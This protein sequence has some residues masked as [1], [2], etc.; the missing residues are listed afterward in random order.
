MNQNKLVTLIMIAVAA[1]GV[2]QAV[3]AYGLNHNLWRPL[4]VMACVLGFLG[5]WALMLAARKARMSRQ[6]D[7]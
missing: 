1:W 4:M 2:F 7:E 3:G 5:F 6:D